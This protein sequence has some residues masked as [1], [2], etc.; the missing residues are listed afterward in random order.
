MEPLAPQ[1]SP[2]YQPC[3]GVGPNR[4]ELC[5]RG[6]VA[7][8]G[9]GCGAC[10]REGV[11]ARTWQMTWHTRG[12]GLGVGMS[13]P[14][15]VVGMHTG[16]G[17]HTLM[18]TW[19]PGH[20]LGPAASSQSR[21]HPEWGTRAQLPRSTWRRPRA[22]LAPQEDGLWPAH[23]PGSA[24][25]PESLGSGACTPELT[26]G[27]ELGDRLFPGRLTPRYDPPQRLGGGWDYGG[28]GRQPAAPP[29]PLPPIRLCVEHI[30]RLL[31]MQPRRLTQPEH[32]IFYRLKCM[33]IGPRPR[34]HP[35]GAG[36]WEGEAA[37]AG[38]RRQRGACGSSRGWEVPIRR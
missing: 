14:M 29:P 35:Q 38:E 12:G 24:A 37:E 20:S 32:L 33:Q 11:W 23:S 36:G 19:P 13:T 25:R 15:G 18:E 4:G 17:A 6:S 21:L 16:V 1:V 34:E 31:R 9:E 28:A 27:V 10:T 30:L 3:G 8:T 22:W 7:H 5:T 26:T 2:P